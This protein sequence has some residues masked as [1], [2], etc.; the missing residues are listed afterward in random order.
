MGGIFKPGP[1]GADCSY[2]RCDPDAGGK[3]RSS[4]EI[5][6]IIVGFGLLFIGITT[7]SSAVEP[8]QDSESFT[9]LFV[10]LGSN[11]LL[12]ILAGTLVTA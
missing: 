9:N 11:P 4:K 8:L 7:M 12:G 5:A 6:S 3:R 2:G 1:S 10:T